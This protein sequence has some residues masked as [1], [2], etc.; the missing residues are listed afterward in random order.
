MSINIHK[1]FSPSTLVHMKN[2]EHPWMGDVPNILPPTSSNSAQN[3]MTRASKLMFFCFSCY[4]WLCLSWWCQSNLDRLCWLT[5]KICI[6]YIYV[7]GERTPSR[8]AFVYTYIIINHKYICR[9]TSWLCDHHMVKPIINQP[10]FDDQEKT[11]HWWWTWGWS[12]NHHCFGDKNVDYP[13]EITMISPEISGGHTFRWDPQVER[14]GHSVHLHLGG[15]G[16]P[17]F[18]LPVRLF[19]C[20][21]LEAG[22]KLVPTTPT[23]IGYIYISPHT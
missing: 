5:Y 4:P 22:A 6:I 18:G 21:C 13:H 19:L 11:T 15:A 20:L 14:G 17:G 23:T 16:G 10:I 12:P 8:N 9:P 3:Y 1:A 2:R 7:V